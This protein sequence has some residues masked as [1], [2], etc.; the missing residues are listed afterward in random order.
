MVGDE[1][2]KGSQTISNILYYSDL[3]FWKSL[4]VLSRNGE[5]QIRF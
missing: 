3:G 2:A 1:S 5:G 4:K